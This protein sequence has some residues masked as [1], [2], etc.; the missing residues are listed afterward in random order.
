MLENVY[1]ILGATTDSDRGILRA[2]VEE[3]YGAAR[4]CDLHSQDENAWSEDVVR[5]LLTWGE[6]QKSRFKVVSL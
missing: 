1:T 5:P 3:L 6:N 4:E 2:K